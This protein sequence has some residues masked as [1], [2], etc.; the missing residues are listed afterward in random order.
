MEFSILF[1][2][3]PSGGVKYGIYLWFFL[4]ILGKIC[5]VFWRISQH[6]WSG[7]RG[8]MVFKIIWLFKNGMECDRIKGLIWRQNTKKTLKF[9]WKL[10]LYYQKIFLLFLSSSATL[11]IWKKDSITWCPN[12]RGSSLSHLV[13]DLTSVPSLSTSDWWQI[14]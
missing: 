10:S 13:K 6:L 12:L 5:V 14:L 7:K 8:I 9:Y 1:W 3:P 2:P 4:N 11:Y